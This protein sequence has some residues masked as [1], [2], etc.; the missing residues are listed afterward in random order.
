MP[1]RL[2]KLNYWANFVSYGWL[3]NGGH[4]SILKSSINWAGRTNSLALSK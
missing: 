4:Q 3:L 1:E 2:S